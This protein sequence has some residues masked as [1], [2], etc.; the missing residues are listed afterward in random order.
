MGDIEEGMEI[1]L[2]VV[3][4]YFAS[5]IMVVISLIDMYAKCRTIHKDQ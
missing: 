2:R 5:N 4:N 1:Y 3:E